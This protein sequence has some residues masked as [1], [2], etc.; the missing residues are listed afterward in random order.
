MDV[1]T[2]L[3]IKAERENALSTLP[4]VLLLQRLSIYTDDAVLL[5]KPSVR[6]AFANFG[7]ASG[8]H[9][10]FGKSSAIMIRCSVVESNRVVA[11]I[12]TC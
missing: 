3:I 8:L 2:A 10:N 11:Q 12:S 1:L 5:V 6:D 7:E 4:R 9:I